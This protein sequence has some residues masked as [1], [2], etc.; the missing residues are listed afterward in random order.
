[1]TE[2]EKQA[3]KELNEVIEGYK[4]Q[5]A[6]LTRLNVAVMET[7]YRKGSISKQEYINLHASVYNAPPPNWN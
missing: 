1:M 6:K 4:E 5:T 7:I 3:V 2:R